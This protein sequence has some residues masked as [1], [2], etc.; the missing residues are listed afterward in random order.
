MITHGTGICEANWG[1]T[2][3]LLGHTCHLTGITKKLVSFMKAVEL[4][5]GTARI[6]Q[7]PVHGHP[8]RH[9]MRTGTEEIISCYSSVIKE[10]LATHQATH[11]QSHPCEQRPLHGPQ[12]S[13]RLVQVGTP[14]S[15]VVTFTCSEM[16]F[17]HGQHILQWDTHV[18]VHYTHV[19]WTTHKIWLH[20]TNII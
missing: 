15:R 5:C 3:K 14:S 20:L 11:T 10:T 19:Q 4:V 2:R 6:T 18:H 9:F 7:G 1:N 13:H 8:W 17:S 12:V 16:S